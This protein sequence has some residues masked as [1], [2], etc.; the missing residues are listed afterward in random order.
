MS[1]G[2]S[3]IGPALVNAPLTPDEAD[4]I[5][6]RV[7][8]PTTPQDGEH[9][10]KRARKGMGMDWLVDGKTITVHVH[11]ASTIDMVKAE[12]QELTKIPFYAISI[13][14]WRYGAESVSA[15]DGDEMIDQVRAK[16]KQGGQITMRADVK[17]KYRTTLR[18]IGF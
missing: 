9:S 10:A 13:T 7:E 2:A 4:H 1:T 18:K 15:N 8:A 12:I 3:S 14:M 11:G 5:G 16:L 17:A 6:D